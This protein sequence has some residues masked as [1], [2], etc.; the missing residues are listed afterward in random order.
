VAE[1][2]TKAIDDRQTGE[3]ACPCCGGALVGVH[4]RRG[5]GASV[6]RCLV[7]YGGWL[8]YSD[9]TLAAEASHNFLWRLRN[10]FGATAR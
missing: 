1:I 5:S 9:L 8:N 6:K 2:N 4:D 3:L 10:M 7:C